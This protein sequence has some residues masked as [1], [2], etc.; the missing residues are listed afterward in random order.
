MNNVFE[1][2]KGWRVHGSGVYERDR[3]R[4]QPLLDHAQIYVICSDQSVRLLAAGM[5]SGMAS[6]FGRDSLR[7]FLLKPQRHLNSTVLAPYS[8]LFG[9]CRTF[10]DQVNTSFALPN[11]TRQLVSYN[12]LIV[13]FEFSERRQCG[14][15]TFVH[16]TNRLKV[17]A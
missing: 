4:L 17:V 7:E 15:A 13:P 3:D 14:L 8:Y 2:A 1:A 12:R 6:I 9:S 10:E 16:I 5:A 11:G